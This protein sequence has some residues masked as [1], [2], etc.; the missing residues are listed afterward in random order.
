MIDQRSV[1]VKAAL[2]NI[3]LCLGRLRLL[4]CL[5]HT[6][7]IFGGVDPRDDVACLDIVAFTHGQALQ[8]TGHSG[9]DES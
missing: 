2:G 1:V 5:A 9:L 8:F 4:L 3:D 6:C 7:L